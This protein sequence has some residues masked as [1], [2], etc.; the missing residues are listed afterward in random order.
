MALT[1]S[2][3]RFVNEYFRCNMNA[4]EAYSRLHPKSKRETA[5][6]A[7]SRL[8]T[9]VDLSDEITRRL[10]ESQISADEVLQRISEQAKGE[11]AAYITS[12][13]EIDIAGLVADGKG[14][15]IKKVKR[16]VRTDRD[17][18][19][20]EYTEFEFHDGQRAL[21]LAGKYHA[22]FTD[23]VDH[24]TK[25]ESFNAAEMKPSEIAERV[26]ALLAVKDDNDKR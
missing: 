3:V 12:T 7:A 18:S 19:Q 21:E 4:T 13:G 1:P 22:M 14:H 16:T 17:G 11:H 15:L 23:R 25:G 10:K 8:M 26:A 5:R 2:D 9:K 20:T 6:R 24:T